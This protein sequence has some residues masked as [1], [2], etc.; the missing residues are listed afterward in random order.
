MLIGWST[1]DLSPGKLLIQYQTASVAL[2]AW[3][4]NL[5]VIMICEFRIL[6]YDFR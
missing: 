5:T 3:V 4:D 2:T 1:Q 6:H